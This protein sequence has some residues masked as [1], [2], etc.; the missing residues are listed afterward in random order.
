M[1]LTIQLMPLTFLQKMIQLNDNQLKQ[2][3]EQLITKPAKSVVP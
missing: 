2:I 3:P 1:I